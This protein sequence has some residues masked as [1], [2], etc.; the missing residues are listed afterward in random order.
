MSAQLMLLQF[1]HPNDILWSVRTVDLLIMQFS[2]VSWQVQMFTSALSCRMLY[3]TL[4]KKE[5]SYHHH[6]KPLCTLACS[7]GN[8][9]L[10]EI[11]LLLRFLMSLATYS[12]I[13]IKLTPEQAISKHFLHN[14]ILGKL[15]VAQ[16]ARKFLAP[17]KTQR[18]T[19]Q[20]P[21]TEHYV[22]RAE[23]SLNT[24]IAVP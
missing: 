16:L 3:C 13:K 10:F 24:Y 17:Y 22:Q 12:R 18:L 8:K 6:H 7:H 4:T 11:C 20:H 19:S 2:P 9:V 21:V 15:L 1:D 5:S 23:R 14:F